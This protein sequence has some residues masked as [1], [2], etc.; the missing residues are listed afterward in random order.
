MLEITL[1]VLLPMVIYLSGTISERNHYRSLAHRERAMAGLPICEDPHPLLTLQPAP[2][3]R[4][5]MGSVVIS[6][7][8]FKRFMAGVANCLLGR[9]ESY[10]ALL[11]R[12][13]R[14][15]IL[16]MKSQAL[17]LDAALVYNV[18]LE[19]AQVLP[20][21]HGTPGA[22]EVLAYGTALIPAERVRTVPTPAS[23]P[24]PAPSRRPLTAPTA[25]PALNP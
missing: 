10:E 5:V 12:A 7:D 18:R 6:L 13:R 11:D 3:A 20:G 4:L 1:I 14:E 17:H 8:V 9:V 15:A 24:R 21:W 16:R 23:D 25:R 2:H 19:T 22:V